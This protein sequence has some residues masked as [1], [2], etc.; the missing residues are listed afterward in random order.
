MDAVTII[1]LP[2]GPLRVNTYIL[3]CG[4]TG[5]AAI[6]DP[7]GEPQKV[8]DAIEREAITPRLILV[9][10]GHPDHILANAALKAVLAIPVYMH[11][12]DVGR[13]TGTP[14]AVD[15]EQETGLRVD[16]TADRLLVDGGELQVGALSI[17]V[18]H[19]PGHT[20]G[21]C[22]FL[23]AG[24]LFTGDTL[25]IGDVG[26]TDGKGASLDQLI[27]SI[28]TKLIDLPDDTRIWPGHDYHSDPTA[29]PSKDAGF[30]TLGQEKKDNPYITDF[31][32]DP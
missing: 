2:L 5:D 13:Y 27:H 10:H 29:P 20:P 24:H 21:S 1:P 25:F 9:T 32:L 8:I 22:C 14:A 7:A 28:A 6:I 17:R 19:T 26:R 15:L 4:Q 30:S 11:A 23:T 16:A 12:A 31:I 18:L 3:G